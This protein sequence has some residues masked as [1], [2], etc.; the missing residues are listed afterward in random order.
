MSCAALCALYADGGCGC[1]A[2]QRLNAV[3]VD[4]LQAAVQ[5]FTTGQ[6]C[7]SREW[8]NLLSR[9]LYQEETLLPLQE[10]RKQIN[11]K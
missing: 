1:G 2:E 10:K 7:R 3:N 5:S 9:H 4:N 6:E 11:V 8:E